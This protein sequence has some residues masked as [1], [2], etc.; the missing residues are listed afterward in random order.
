MLVKIDSNLADGFTYLMA[1]KY[2]SH[3]GTSHSHLCGVV[4]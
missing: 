4:G 2:L 1:D 3:L